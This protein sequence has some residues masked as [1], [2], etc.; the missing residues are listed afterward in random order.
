MDA[1]GPSVNFTC[2]KCQRRYSIADDKVRGRTVKI[3]CKNC[4]NIVTVQG[5]AGEQR[6][7]M[8]SIAEVEKL[9]AQKPSPNVPKSQWEVD[10]TRAQPALDLSVEWFAMIQGKQT[11]PH[12]VRTLNERVGAGDV[13]L[14]TYLWRKGMTDWKRAQDVPELSILFA[15]RKTGAIPVAPANGTSASHGRPPSPPRTGSWAAVVPS[16]G[17]SAE[18]SLAKLVLE[19]GA[20]DASTE[21][22]GA[23][24]GTVEA[25]GSITIEPV[26]TGKR[27]KAPPAQEEVDPFK[28]LDAVI[29]PAK[30]PP[31]GESTRFFIAQAGV[32][33]RNPPWKVALFIASP[34]AVVVS[35]LYALSSLNVV[36]LQVIRVD[37]TGHEV[38]KSIF[39]P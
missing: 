33:K 15:G 34:I 31:P 16:N 11:G 12:T 27:K 24:G 22:H 30:L 37:D 4:Q 39:S 23:L 17:R 20:P 7:G 38:K 14:R 35:A 19:D 25:E 21:K 9:R 26:G 18:D 3:R 28:A 2:D 10:P 36:P 5:P 8:M 6:T 29:D 13:S 1:L 32:H